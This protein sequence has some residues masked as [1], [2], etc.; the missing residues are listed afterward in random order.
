MD[1]G[2]QY[3]N[4]DPFKVA[5]RLHQSRY[6]ASVLR[7][8]YDTYGNRLEPSA[9]LGLANYFDGLGVR[10]ALRRRYPNY[11]ATRDAD[12]L[13]SEHVPFNLFAPLAARARLAAVLLERMTGVAFSSGP[14][15]QFE[16]APTP[17][18]NYLGDKTS[19]DAYFSGLDEQGRRLGV[20]V[21]VKF[22]E[23]AYAI[24]RTEARR[25]RD[26]E[27]PYWVITRSSAA[28]LED[29]RN[30]LAT[31]ELRQIWRNHLLG[32]SMLRHRELDRFVSVTLYPAGNRHFAEALPRYRACVEPALTTDI[33]GI[34]FEDY[35]SW[36]PETDELRAWKDYLRDRYIV[37]MPG[38]PRAAPDAAAEHCF[39]G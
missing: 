19:F 34:T 5:A 27:S 37:T 2:P 4:D 39:V 20:G 11:S 8:G 3:A 1:V 14:E 32:L 28:F 30:D 29:R 15:L 26:I 17:E 22:T 16:W 38:H 31:D 7:V 33:V 36:L 6:R 13:R 21:E 12:M 10:E 9:A 18:G 25:V 23:G 35:V 24:G